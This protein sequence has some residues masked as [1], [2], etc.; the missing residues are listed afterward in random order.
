MMALSFFS[1]IF[2]FF[3]PAVKK[4]PVARICSAVGRYGSL[5]RRQ[6]LSYGI[7]GQ[8]PLPSRRPQ[9]RVLDIGYWIHYLPLPAYPIFCCLLRQV[10][11]ERSDLH[12]RAGR[13]VP[14]CLLFMVILGAWQ[15]HGGREVARQLVARVDHTSVS[16]EITIVDWLVSYPMYSQAYILETH[17]Q[18]MQMNDL[19]KD[20]RVFQI[21]LGFIYRRT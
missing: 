15:S 21:P 14:S 4:A 16:W 3:F 12:P 11:G 19:W 13:L 6:Q 18:V 9:Y 20:I 2:L 10:N 8:S 17:T 5:N 1:L 7:V